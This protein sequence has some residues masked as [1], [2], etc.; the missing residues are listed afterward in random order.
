M[1]GRDP[2]V[3]ACWVQGNMEKIMSGGIR[4]AFMAYSRNPALPQFMHINGAVSE[5]FLPGH[6]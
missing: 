6:D 5:G 2:V 3:A 1:Y 4:N